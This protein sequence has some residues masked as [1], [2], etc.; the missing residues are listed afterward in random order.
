MSLW[1]GEP[2]RADLHRAPWSSVCRLARAVGIEAREDEG[3]GSRRLL[4]AWRVAKV[5][6]AKNQESATGMQLQTGYNT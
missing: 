1:P 6:A 3:D 2:W 4:V 5:V